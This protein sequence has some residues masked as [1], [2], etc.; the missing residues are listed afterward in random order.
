MFYQLVVTAGMVAL[1]FGVVV[2]LVTTPEL[3]SL[4]AQGALPFSRLMLAL[5]TLLPM[6]FYLVGPIAAVIAV[7]YCYYQWSRH[8]EI[9]M[10]RAAGLSNLALA[11][12]GMTAGVAAMLFTA[13]MSLYLLPVSFR[14]FEDINYA[15]GLALTITSLGE[16]YRQNIAPNLSIS[17]RKRTSAE[18]VE[19]VTVWDDR[20]PDAHITVLAE[21]GHFL[22]RPKA[23]TRELEQIIVLDKGS[24]LEQ[25]INAE[26]A[27]PVVFEDFVVP[28][29]RSGGRSKIRDWRG[30]FEEHIGRL[31]DPPPA[32]REVPIDYGQWIA[33]G[34]KRLLLP[35]LC[36]GYAAF[37]LGVMLR[38]DNPRAG[39]VWRL[40]ALA[41]VTALWHG[42][43]V[44]VHS[45]IVTHPDL[46]RAYYLMA[47]IPEAIG[48]ALILASDRPVRRRAVYP[49]P[50]LAEPRPG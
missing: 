37:A 19:G 45:F 8:S 35:L 11:L 3:F 27:R 29:A 20:K 50:L 30:F 15:A 46:A 22:V 18:F 6:V 49:S 10:L 24:Y 12:P 39:R 47:L 26:R 1:V 41:G 4:L 36:L 17:F 16:G 21:R 44:V 23:G 7:G 28:L 33:E 48:M 40:L 31:L 43:T 14:T 32:I 9:V 5:A 34:H 25:Y 42:L 2:L 38:G 13:S